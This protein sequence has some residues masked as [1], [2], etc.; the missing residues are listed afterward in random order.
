MKNIE[1]KISKL[2]SENLHR[3]FNYMQSPQSSRVTMG[4]KVYIMLGSNSY[5]DLSTN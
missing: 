2:K 4:N 5:L 3:K 1:R